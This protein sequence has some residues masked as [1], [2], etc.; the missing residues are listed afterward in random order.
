LGCYFKRSRIAAQRRDDGTIGVEHDRGFVVTL[1]GAG[2]DHFA[3]RFN[4][5]RG[6]NAE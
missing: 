2:C 6:G 1:P 3:R 4:R 5:E